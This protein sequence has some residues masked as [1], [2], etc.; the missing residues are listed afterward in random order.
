MLSAAVLLARVFQEPVCLDAR[1]LG[2]LSPARTID[3][4]E[5]GEENWRWRGG[6]SW[7]VCKRGRERVQVAL[8]AFLKTFSGVATSVP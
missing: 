5:G 3:G 7:R 1:R 8:S 6:C 2:P 4:M